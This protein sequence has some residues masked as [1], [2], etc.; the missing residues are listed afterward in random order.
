MPKKHQEN[1]KALRILKNF[2]IVYFVNS[3]ISQY[4]ASFAFVDVENNFFR[5]TFFYDL[6]DMNF[7]VQQYENVKYYF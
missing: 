7:V 5:M 4:V 3:R 2:C 6:D 1:F